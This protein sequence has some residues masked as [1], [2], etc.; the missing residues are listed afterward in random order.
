[1]NQIIGDPPDM[2]ILLD[3]SGSMCDPISPLGGMTKMAVMK[4]ALTNLVTS[5]DARIDFGMMKFPGDRNC[6]DAMLTNPIMPMN[7][8]AISSTLAG[9]P[10]GL[11]GCA[12]S[13]MLGGNTPT[14]LAV[15]NAQ[16]Y[17]ATIPVN[18]VGQ[19][20]LLATDGEPNCGAVQSDGS[21]APTNDE[22]VAAIQSLHD[23]GI[24]TFVL[25]FGSGFASDP[26]TLMRMATAGGT[27]M[28]YNASS[29]AELETALDT[30]AAGIIPPSCTVA[31]DGGARDPALFQVSFDGG[32]LIPRDTS[33]ASGWDYD[34]GT[35]TITFYGTECDTVES[36]G[37]VDI[38]ID[39]GCPG[40]LV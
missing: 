14:F 26:T 32:A 6:G 10:T 29:A 37:V 20:V 12:S 40:P 22:T 27:G 17:Y 7:G 25:G 11:F 15:Q 34:P 21:T 31:L 16:S 23:A 38:N 30:I 39:Y 18:P 8:A 28:P 9:F 3:V 4:N 24:N 33:H 35:N 13:P 5:F 2:L 1:M 36:G 19:Y